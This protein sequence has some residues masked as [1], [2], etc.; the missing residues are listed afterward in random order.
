MSY[1]VYQYFQ[2][3]GKVPIIVRVQN[4]ATETTFDIGTTMEIRAAYPGQWSTNL[5]D[6]G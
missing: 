1:A 2:N 5:G 6:S 3:G 4:S